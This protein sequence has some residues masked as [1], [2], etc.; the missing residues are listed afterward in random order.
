MAE[1]SFCCELAREDQPRE[2]LPCVP[3]DCKIHQT[4]KPQGI[5]LK[6]FAAVLANGYKTPSSVDSQ[7]TQ[8]EQTPPISY[9]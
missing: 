8:A 2:K 5:H 4:S 3:A 1:I 7:K 6:H 9:S